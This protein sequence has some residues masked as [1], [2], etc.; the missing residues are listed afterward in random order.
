[1]ISDGRRRL[2]PVT[3]RPLG[4]VG[5]PC[6]VHR[7]RHHPPGPCGSARSRRLTAL[8]IRPAANVKSRHAAGFSRSLG[9]FRDQAATW[10]SAHLRRIFA[11][12]S[13]L[14]STMRARRRSGPSLTRRLKRSPSSPV[15]EEIVGA[16]EA[17][18]RTEAV[19]QR[20][21][22]GAY[23]LAGEE[24]GQFEAGGVLASR[25]VAPVPP[26]D[27][28]DDRA[29]AE[30]DHQEGDRDEGERVD[31]GR[32]G[33]ASASPSTP[34]PRHRLV[35]QRGCRG[36]PWRG[37]GDGVAAFAV[38]ACGRRHDL[39][40]LGQEG[41]DLRLVGRFADERGDAGPG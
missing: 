17:E 16:V 15:A 12:R 20:P 23:A 36:S 24:V 22:A 8:P 6:A 25:A 30:P 10:S 3:A 2:T 19:H 26:V 29:E 21:A 27:G 7:Y 28:A 14:I 13:S 39:L 40:H 33:C 32:R 37:Q 34:G 5:S 31:D 38:Q 18:V 4:T 11:A 35:E 1:M 41:I 9:L